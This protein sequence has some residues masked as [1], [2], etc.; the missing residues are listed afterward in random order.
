MLSKSLSLCK[1]KDF[2]IRISGISKQVKKAFT[3]WAHFF[4]SPDFTFLVARV[5]H[6]PTN[7]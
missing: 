2:A 3:D 5:R 4:M 6:T 1:K 7:S